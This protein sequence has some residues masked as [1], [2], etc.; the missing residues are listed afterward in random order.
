MKDCIICNLKFN[1]RTKTELCCS[2]K[3]SH[4]YQLE[5]AKNKYHQ[6][7]KFRELKKKYDS[8]RAKWYTHSKKFKDSLKRYR[9]TDKYR[10]SQIRY[11][12]SK[13]GKLTKRLAVIRRRARLNKIILKFTK[14]QW[15]Q[16]LK[17]THGFCCGY[18]RKRHYVGIWNLTLDHIYSVIKAYR[19]FLK[20]GIKRVYTID[21]VQP[22]CKSCNCRK[23][24]DLISK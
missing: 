6:F 18:K 23:G 3:C 1:H 24:D 11:K 12:N 13:K 5:Y 22:L 9:K 2:K 20:T 19:D 10:I 15:K 16:K 4:Q 7:P 14:E 17:S 21:D 8:K